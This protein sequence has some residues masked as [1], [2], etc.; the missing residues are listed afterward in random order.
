[1]PGENCKEER[2]FKGLDCATPGPHLRSNYTLTGM[3]TGCC[4]SD[5]KWGRQSHQCFTQNAMSL[6]VPLLRRTQKVAGHHRNLLPAVVGQ[7]QH[8]RR[9]R[10]LGRDAS[11][12]DQRSSPNKQIKIIPKIGRCQIDDIRR[13]KRIS[14]ILRRI[15]YLC[16]FRAM[17]RI[18]RTIHPEPQ[19]T[20][21]KSPHNVRRKMVV[22]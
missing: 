21:T 14:K 16:Q 18:S 8:A 5:W 15:T 11:G 22:A 17:T 6:H 4:T 20:N 2:T 1:M 19:P 9:V 12:Y 10:F 7:F 13:F 3:R